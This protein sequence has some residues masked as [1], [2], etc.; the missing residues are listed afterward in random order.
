MSESIKRTKGVGS[1]GVPP[2]RVDGGHFSPLR[3]FVRL[4]FFFLRPCSGS[5]SVACVDRRLR[6]PLRTKTNGW[7]DF[8]S[9]AG[10]LIIDA[11]A[12]NGVKADGRTGADMKLRI[13]RS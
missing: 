11:A 2:L 1:P 6:A 8:A 12:D 5:D 13:K 10:A 4:M 7:R 9:S 3:P